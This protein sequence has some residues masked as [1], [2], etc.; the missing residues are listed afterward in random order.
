M[1]DRNW[2]VSIGLAAVGIAGALLGSAVQHVLTLDRERSMATEERQSEAYVALLNAFDMFR[3]S[4]SEKAGGREREADELLR[5]YELEAGAAVRRIAIF[6]DKAVVEALAEWYRQDGLRPCE[7][8]LT[9]ELAT[10]ERMRTASLGA[11]QDV[12]PSDLAAVA[13]RCAI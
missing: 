4:E 12:S 6:G 11:D 3:M 1:R 7:A 5:R 10:W 9:P 8:I 13:G 2:V